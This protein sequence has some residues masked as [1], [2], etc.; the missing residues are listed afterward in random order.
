M[1]TLTILMTCKEQKHWLSSCEYSVQF[2]LGT[3]Y[4]FV[5]VINRWWQKKRPKAFNLIGQGNFAAT[6]TEIQLIEWWIDV[7]SP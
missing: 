4:F 3:A 7:L 1:D 5:L 6:V 2:A